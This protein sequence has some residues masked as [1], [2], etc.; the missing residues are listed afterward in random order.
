MRLKSARSPDRRRLRPPASAARSGLRSR[1]VGPGCRG[2]GHAATKE[3]MSAPVQP[4]TGEQLNACA[5]SG[6]SGPLGALR[7][8]A[9]V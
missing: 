1:P 8:R 5:R 6:H 2:Q 9:G 4:G 3:P 7:N